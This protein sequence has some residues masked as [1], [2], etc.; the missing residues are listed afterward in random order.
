MTGNNDRPRP[1]EPQ[2]ASMGAGSETMSTSAKA[3][4][5]N[6]RIIITTLSNWRNHREGE[7][8][9]RPAKEFKESNAK[10]ADRALDNKGEFYF[11]ANGRMGKNIFRSATSIANRSGVMI[12]P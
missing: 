10:R 2:F 5:A 4:K 12:F 1:A 11:G 8:V 9:A 3:T 6:R 7:E